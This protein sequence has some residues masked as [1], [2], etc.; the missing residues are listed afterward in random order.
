MLNIVWDIDDVLNSLMFEWLVWCNLDISNISYEDIT[1]NLPY[2]SLNISREKYLS[3]LDEFRFEAYSELKPNEEILKWFEK[4]GHK[5]NHIV[6]T[7]TPLA[8]AQISAQ[9]VMKHF[10]Q[11]IRQF[12]FIPS[13]RDGAKEIIYHKN[14]AQ[15][16]SWFGKC[17]I[18][19]DDSEKNI[20]EVKSTR[21]CEYIKTFLVKQPWN[22]GTEIKQILKWV[23]ELILE[24]DNENI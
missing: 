23:D 8:T 10:K 16:L 2:K 24:H 6:L 19:I 12:V 1:D 11:W 15:W 18:F 21:G 4:N 3:S 7:A 13:K 14:K 17:D 22:N 9:W 5:A 20:N